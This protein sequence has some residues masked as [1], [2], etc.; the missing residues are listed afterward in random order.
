MM[1][2][3]EQHPTWVADAERGCRAFCDNDA[4]FAFC[5]A[6]GSFLSAATEVA[7]ERPSKPNVAGRTSDRMLLRQHR[8]ADCGRVP[9]PGKSH[10][11]GFR[12]AG[13]FA[14]NHLARSNNSLSDEQ[15]IEA[16][17]FWVPALAPE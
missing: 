12:K 3:S 5:H 13:P 17:C 9:T 8:R 1:D 15:S 2:S 7:P 4:P 10:R 6:R 16:R 11:G 14:Q